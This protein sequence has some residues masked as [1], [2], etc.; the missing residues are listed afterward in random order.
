[1]IESVPAPHVTVSVE[2]VTAEKDMGVP[3]TGGIVSSLEGEGVA[4]ELSGFPQYRLEKT[5]NTRILKIN[6]DSSFLIGLFFIR[7]VGRVQN[8]V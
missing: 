7:S 8:V 2:S 1:V 6:L 4:G 5:K 3:I